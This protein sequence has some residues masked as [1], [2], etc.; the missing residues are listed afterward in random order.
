MLYRNTPAVNSL[1]RGSRDARRVLTDSRYL[2]F[3]EWWGPLGQRDNLA[4]V[5]GRD[6]AKA[7]LGVEPLHGA[8]RTHVRSLG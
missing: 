8:L 7:L 2:V 4:A 3:D 6:E 1:W 5:I